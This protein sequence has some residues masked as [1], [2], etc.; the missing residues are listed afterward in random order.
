MVKTSICKDWTTT[1][2]KKLKNILFGSQLF[3][4]YAWSSTH[5]ICFTSENKIDS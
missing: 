5:I 1:N 4:F 2:L 3:K